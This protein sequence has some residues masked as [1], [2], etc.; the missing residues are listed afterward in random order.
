MHIDLVCLVGVDAAGGRNTVVMSVLCSQNCGWISF[1]S[2]NY[3]K[4]LKVLELRCYI[5]INYNYRVEKAV[6]MILG[7]T[8]SALI[9]EIILS[10]NNV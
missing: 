7:P 9:R 5:L 8:Y 6:V 1:L 2:K 3:V 10:L 4:I